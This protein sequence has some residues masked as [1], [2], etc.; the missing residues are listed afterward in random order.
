[1]Y[2]LKKIKVVSLAYTVTLIY[3]I[4]GV[5]LGIF[6]ALLKTNPIV[7]NSVNPDLLN[8][9]YLQIILL[10]PIAYAAGGFI[11]SIIVGYVYNLVSKR[12]GGVAIQLVKSSK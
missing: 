4:L 3:F 10:Y 2:R 6:V 8:L 11:I 5:I 1:M 9:S 7:T 12:T